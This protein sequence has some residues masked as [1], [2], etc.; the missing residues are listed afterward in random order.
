MDLF[1]T[2]GTRDIFSAIIQQ[3]ARLENM[4]N[5]ALSSGIDL[6]LNKNYK[7]AIKEFKR[8]IGL[9][10]RSSYSVTASN[11]MAKAYLQLNDVENAIKAYKTSINLDPSNAAAHIK[12]GNL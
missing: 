7:E 2:E 12:L 11:Y 1:A 4:A 10:P 6:Y 8:S 3:P 9:A 5:Q